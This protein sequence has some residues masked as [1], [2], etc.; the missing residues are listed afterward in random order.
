MA[1]CPRVGVR[2]GE[3]SAVSGGG[4]GGGGAQGIMDF[5]GTALKRPVT[6]VVALISVIMIAILALSSMKQDISPDLD[7]PA[8][9]IIQGYGGMAPDQMEGYIVSTY[10]LFFLYVPGIEHI[11]SKSIQNVSIIK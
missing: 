8:I 5:V 7:I 10:E 6:V 4:G 9:Y 11:E 2:S 3:S 1:V